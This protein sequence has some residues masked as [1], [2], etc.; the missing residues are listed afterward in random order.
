MRR[1][2]RVPGI[3]LEPIGH[4]WA[5]FSP[6]S[7]ETILLNDESAAILEVLQSG[8][9]SAAEVCLALSDDSGQSVDQ[10]MPFVDSCWPRLIE[11]GLVQERQSLDSALS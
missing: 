7:G 2:A 3:L 5:A 8:A 11:A 10:L 1:F 4:V 9:A 6:A